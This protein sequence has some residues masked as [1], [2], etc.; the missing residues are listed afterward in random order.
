MTEHALYHELATMRWTDGG[1]QEW[2]TDLSFTLTVHYC[3]DDVGQDLALDL[4]F[5]LEIQPD[6]F[7]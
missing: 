3:L 4:H 1:I 6:S 2:L 5:H 7:G